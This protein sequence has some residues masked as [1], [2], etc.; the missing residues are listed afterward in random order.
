MLSTCMGAAHSFEGAQNVLLRFETNLYSV[1][2]ADIPSDSTQ[3]T[4][5]SLAAATLC[6]VLAQIRQLTMDTTEYYYL[7]LLA[8]FKTNMSERLQS[9]EQ[10]TLFHDWAQAGLLN[11][12]NKMHARP[13]RFSTL[14]TVLTFTSTVSEENVRELFFKTAVAAPSMMN[15]L[16]ADIYVK[17]TYPPLTKT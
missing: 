17:D 8:L 9:S 14:K 13:F 4:K 5:L 16:I 1:F 2:H 15:K 11:Y 3:T 12:V 10:V 6:S 7:K